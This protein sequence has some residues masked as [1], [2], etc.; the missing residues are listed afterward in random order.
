MK[1][2]TLA[3]VSLGMAGLLLC[4]CD[5]PDTAA[6]SAVQQDVAVTVFPAAS[7]GRASVNMSTASSI[8]A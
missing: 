7:S 2:A 1:T 8:S 4:S 6:A 5:K 3:L